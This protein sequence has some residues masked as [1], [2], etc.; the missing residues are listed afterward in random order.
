MGP[1]AFLANRGKVDSDKMLKGM[2]DNEENLIDFEHDHLS[3]YDDDLIELF[4]FDQHL[5]D[6]I[7]S[8]Q[9]Y[10]ETEDCSNIKKDSDMAAKKSEDDFICDFV[11]F[12]KTEYM[13]VCHGLK[14][15]SSG[16]ITEVLPMEQENV[17][18]ILYDDKK[19]DEIEEAEQ[20]V[21]VIQSPRQRMRRRSNEELDQ[22]RCHACDFPDCG[23]SYTKSSHLKAHRRLHTGEKPY[24]CKRADCGLTFARS[25]ELTRHNRKHTGEKPFKCEFCERSFARSDHLALHK[26]RHVSRQ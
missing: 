9:S 21:K 8:D 16:T 18:I 14:F 4:G 6:E 22:R 1:V 5:W 17:Q 19:S 13:H 26:K 23:K 20:Q 3:F 24:K 10:F 12:E 15:M 7:S 25:D 11:Q 2:I